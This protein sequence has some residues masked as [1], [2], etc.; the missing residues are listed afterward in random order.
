VCLSLD[1]LSCCQVQWQ[2]GAQVFVFFGVEQVHE[3]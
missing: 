3:Q 1:W 2:V